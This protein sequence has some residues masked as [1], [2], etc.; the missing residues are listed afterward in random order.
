MRVA[1]DRPDHS[2]HVGVALSQN[3][4]TAATASTVTLYSADGLIAVQVRSK[5]DLFLA[6]RVFALSRADDRKMSQ[7]S[8]ISTLQRVCDL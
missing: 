1:P 5:L 2:E 3:P 8:C 6:A 4:V 7:K